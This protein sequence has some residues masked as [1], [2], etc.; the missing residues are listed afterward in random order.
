MD[1]LIYLLDAI[2]LV[3]LVTMMLFATK[4]VK[5]KND[6]VGK[7]QNLVKAV[8]AFGVYIVLN[9]LRLYAEGQFG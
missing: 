9:A 7:K 6:P 2:V 1:I 4:A 3:A 5:A 8:A